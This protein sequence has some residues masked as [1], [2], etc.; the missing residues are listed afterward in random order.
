MRTASC[1]RS[2][3]FA[4]VAIASALFLAACTLQTL[5]DEESQDGPTPDG[6]RS[7]LYGITKLPAETTPGQGSGTPVIEE[8]IVRGVVTEN[9]LGCRVDSVCLLHIRVNSEVAVVVYHYGEWPPCLNDKAASAG[10][11]LQEGDEVEAFAKVI[12][13]GELTTCDSEDYY[14]KK[15]L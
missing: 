3:T 13:G 2:A 12:E 1:Q 14:V 5:T 7:P 10:M 4:L 6:E 11:L 8:R 15:L 9:D